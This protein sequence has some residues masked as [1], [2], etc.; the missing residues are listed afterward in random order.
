MVID[1]RSMITSLCRPAR[2]ISG[3][4]KDL[5]KRALLHTESPVTLKADLFVHSCANLRAGGLVDKVAREAAYVSLKDC[6]GLSERGGAPEARG[7]SPGMHTASQ[8]AETLSE[9]ERWYPYGG[10][11]Q[12]E[13]EEPEGL[14]SLNAV[15]HRL[16]HRSS[17]ITNL[18]RSEHCLPV[19]VSVRL[20]L[21]LILH[22]STAFRKSA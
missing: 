8:S 16:C 15:A 9:Q 11:G 13:K 21:S 17:T 1:D 7:S 5:C 20:S 4:V 22:V 12:S 6:G 2:R 18:C 14:T 10:E 19:C 3:V